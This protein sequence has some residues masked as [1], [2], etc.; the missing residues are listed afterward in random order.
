[1]KNK[2]QDTN[3]SR[4]THPPASTNHGRFGLNFDQA[5]LLISILQMQNHEKILRLT[6]DST[7]GE[8]FKS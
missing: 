1:M 6:V 7:T 2:F 3:V 8:I 5:M 4:S